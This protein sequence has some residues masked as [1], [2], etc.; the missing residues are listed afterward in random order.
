MR[1]IDVGEI[2]RNIKEMCI[3]ANHYLTKDMDEALKCAIQKEASPIGK[4]VL[5]QLQEN[6]NIAAEDRIPICQDTGMAVIFM[7]I[8]QEVHFQGDDDHI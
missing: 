1:T 3:E 7:E 8:G 5:E 4:Q 6:L 2:T